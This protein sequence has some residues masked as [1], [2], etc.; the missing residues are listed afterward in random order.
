MRICGAPKV[1]GNTYQLPCVTSCSVAN[2]HQS[3]WNFQ[4]SNNI[5]QDI[6]YKEYSK[7]CLLL[8]WNSFCMQPTQFCYF[9][10]KSEL[11]KLI[12]NLGFE[13]KT[14]P[15][16]LGNLILT[17][18]SWSLVNL[19]SPSLHRLFRLKSEPYKISKSLS[20]PV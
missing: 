14:F 15:Q 16:T 12:V 3:D 4:L 11:H 6:L 20:W 17:A 9:S 5:K 1:K 13:R 19:C 7:R 18:L 8:I 10:I 2:S